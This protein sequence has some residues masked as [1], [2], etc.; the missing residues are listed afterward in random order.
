L[1]EQSSQKASNNKVLPDLII[2]KDPFTLGIRPISSYVYAPE[3]SILYSSSLNE[4]ERITFSSPADL[5]SFI[6]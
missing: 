3:V 1:W 5:A 6:N 4:E 2:A